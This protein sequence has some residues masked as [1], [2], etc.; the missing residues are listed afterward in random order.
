MV[1]LLTLSAP[2]SFFYRIEFV[3]FRTAIS[4]PANIYLFKVNNRKTRK[5]CEICSKLTMKIPER[6]PDVVLVFLLLILNIFHTFFL[7]F[8]WCFE[9]VNVFWGTIVNF[10]IGGLFHIR[11]IMFTV[12]VKCGALLK[13][14]SLLLIFNNIVFTSVCTLLQ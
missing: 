10:L 12:I 9:R 2:T 5:R 11:V 7:F 3:I 14:V 6:R 13:A 4:N 8:Y 1:S